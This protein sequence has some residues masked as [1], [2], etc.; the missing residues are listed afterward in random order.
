M[1][2]ETDSTATGPRR[3]RE[4]PRLAVAAALVVLLASLLLVLMYARSEHARDRDLRKARMAEETTQVLDLM[5]QR[6]LAY[7]LSTRGGASLF[8]S[9]ERPT[10]Q[11]WRSYVDGLQIGRR[12]G[13]NA[14]G[15]GA[16]IPGDRLREFQLERRSD[17]EGLFKLHPRGV[18]EAYGPVVYVE[19]RRPEHD[20]IDGYDMLSEPVRRGAMEAARDSG[21]SRLTGKLVLQR[22]FDDTPQGA[23]LYTPVYRGGVLPASVE[24]RG[25]ALRGWTY[26]P[27]RMQDFVPQSLA[28]LPRTMS[29]RITDV[30]GGEAAEL[31]VDQDYARADAAAGRD[32]HS[33]NQ[34]FYGRTWRI[35]FIALEAT[36]AAS[37]ARTTVIVGL[38][39]ALLLAAVTWSLARTGVHA[40]QLAARMSESY[41]RS[42]SR[43]RSA[44]VYSPVGKALLDEDDRVVDANL[45]LAA[46]VG[47]PLEQLIGA[48]MGGFFVDG[49]DADE[50]DSEE[51]GAHARDGVYR[52]SRILRRSDGS[53]RRVRLFTAP[54]PGE[55]GDEV[56]RLVQIDD[57]TDWY[58]AEER[59]RALNRTLEA[60]V[61]A[62]TQELERANLELE[63]FSY[64]V[65]HDLRAPLRTI[66]GFSRLLND[67]YA[68]VIDDTGRDYLGRI[69][70]ATARMDALIDALLQMARLSRA[71]VRRR[72]L[73][74]S[75][76]AGQVVADLR[77]AEPEREVVVEIDDGL[78]AQG[79]PT[80]VANLLQNLVGNAWKF[81]AGRDDAQILIG[82]ARRPDGVEAFFVRDNGAGF[83]QDYA[84]KLFRP[85]QRL[86]AQHE[87][88]GH[89]I[90]LASVKRIVERHCGE[91]WAEGREGEGACFWFTLPDEQPGDDCG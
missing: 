28:T 50:V 37:P 44:M 35:D 6:L 80:L 43:F 76:M 57:V 32:R 38:L 46:I 24:A 55:A 81:T 13:P 3:L 78:A 2:G 47:L 72:D 67:R 27:L 79:D 30:T 91:V 52:A 49:R 1:I 21:E 41:R 7:E 14:L 64:S 74:L 71:Q 58:R 53:R 10:A 85:F 73:D 5:S 66:D 61:A 9:V 29:M 90:G 45:A 86:H 42:E 68:S 11:Q 60:R 87:F 23:I 22:R 39:A 59:V 33:V 70:A 4:D 89:G 75:G 84:S 62:R 63:A 15:Y 48:D 16:Y 26:A 83:S 65:S 18:R 82:H 19:P 77:L 25:A 34:S 36:S 88:P 54:V 20:G 40:Q 31:Y 56:V 12:A 17:G 69:R 8:A 51:A